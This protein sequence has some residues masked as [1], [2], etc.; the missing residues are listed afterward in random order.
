M[1]TASREDLS[2]AAPLGA[3]GYVAVLPSLQQGQ[4]SPVAGRYLVPVPQSVLALG[5]M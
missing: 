3:Q 5:V 1:V 4:P 2:S